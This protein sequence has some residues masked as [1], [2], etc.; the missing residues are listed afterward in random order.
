[1]LMKVRKRK[2]KHSA[3][4]R[5]IILALLGILLGVNVYL[6]NAR[7]IAGNR[8]P[9]PFGVGVAVVLSGSMEPE[10]SVDDV[11]IVR[12]SGSYNIN[13]IVVYDTGREMVVHRII[14]QSGDT[15]IT[16][17]DANNTPDEPIKADAVKGK[18]IFSIP[19]AGIAVKALRSPAGIIVIILTAFLLTEGSFRRK[20][21]SD[22]NKIN[23]IKAEIRRLKAEQAEQDKESK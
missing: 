10:L 12:E 22:E 1:M 19:Y 17:G 5:R 21:E 11:I 20:K 7:N 18:V 9:M 14:E 3:L 15:V 13:D 16:K 23:A 6:A 2:H 4:I 8:L